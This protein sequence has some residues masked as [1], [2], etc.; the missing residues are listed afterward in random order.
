MQS[1]GVLTRWKVQSGFVEQAIQCWRKPRLGNRDRDVRDE[2]QTGVIFRQ[3]LTSKPAWEKLQRITP[4][5]ELSRLRCLNKP[6]DDHEA[7]SA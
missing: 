1:N 5:I 3:G 4:T 7:Q 2:S 6:D